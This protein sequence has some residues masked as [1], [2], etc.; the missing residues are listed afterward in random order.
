MARLER[1]AGQTQLE[2][3]DAQLEV[4]R[5]WGWDW[6]RILEHYKMDDSPVVV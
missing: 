4:Y 1:K 3:F 6:F 5:C 2:A